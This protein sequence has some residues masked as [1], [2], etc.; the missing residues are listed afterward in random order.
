MRKSFQCKC[1]HNNV[2]VCYYMGCRSEQCCDWFHS[3]VFCPDMPGVIA[4]LPPHPF[5]FLGHTRGAVLEKSM[6]STRLSLCM[7]GKDM[8]HFKDA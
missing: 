2:T 7:I 4:S 5:S 1:E 3:I 8:H 6:G